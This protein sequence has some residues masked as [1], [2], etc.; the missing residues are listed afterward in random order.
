MLASLSLPLPHS[1]SPSMDAVRALLVCGECHTQLVDP[2]TLDCGHT[3]CTSHA[4]CTMC[5]P[6]PTHSVLP[7]GVHYFSALLPST[8]RN[9]PTPPKG[10]D[11]AILAVSALAA[12]PPSGWPSHLLDA[13]QCAI[14][15]HPSFEPVTTPC[16]HVRNFPT[17]I[18]RGL[19]LTFRHRRS[20][21]NAWR[22]G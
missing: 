1:P 11:T 19:P 4:S 18:S 6:P 20:A 22:T 8:A 5:T 3:V 17:S 14:C 13:L 10:I 16:Q 21:L 12:R 2:I 9:P 7:N 15:H